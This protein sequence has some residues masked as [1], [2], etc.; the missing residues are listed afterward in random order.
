MIKMS[1]PISLVSLLLLAADVIGLIAAFAFSYWLR[2]GAA[3]PWFS[4]PIAWPI[5]ITL[6][7]LYIVDA[8][9]TDIQLSGMRTPIRTVVGIVFAGILISVLVYAGGFL[10]TS[11]PLFGRGT[12]PVA[13]ALFGI[14]ATAWRFYIAR[15]TK[16]RARNIRWLVLGGGEPADILL[17]D[18]KNSSA[19]GEM[20]LYGAKQDSTLPPRINDADALA[21]DGYS[22]IIVMPQFKLA[23]ET[24]K[25]LMEVRFRGIRVYDLADFY[26]QF[27]FKLP[28]MH[29]R[30]GWFIFSHGF[31]LL[32]NP[33]GLRL[34]RV[35]DVVFSL[36]FL[37]LFSPLI[38]LVGLL[39]R[40]TS[41]GPV[42]YRQIRTGENGKEFTLYK[43][44]SMRVDAE[45]HGPS[46]ASVNDSRVT[47]V[48]RIL[49]ATRLDEIPQV[50]NVLRG[51]MSFIGPRPER[52]VFNQQL[53][54]EIPF[55]NLRHL[56]SPGITG[57]AQVMYPYGASVED[58]REKLQYDL[59]YI[60]NYSLLLDITILFKTLRVIL[61]GKGR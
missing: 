9:R 49:R 60:K 18:F 32:H 6:L 53:E 59:Y 46:W 4:W 29:V 39:T 35:L 15:W 61:L 42:L 36:L 16:H 38:V 26:E 5:L 10:S 33:I 21:Q 37:A 1:F 20:I 25:Q 12:F 19:E 41:R 44:R 56:V 31:N 55:Y 14:W 40:L 52:P 47:P 7:S 58:A 8:Y 57:W 28:V 54:K 51:E 3:L 48:G 45:S 2:Q 22:G 11:V 50:I 17:R 43:F 30:S 34:K 24:V 23:D 13:L 27:W